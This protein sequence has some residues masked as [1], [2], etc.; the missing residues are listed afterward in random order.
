ME[1]EPAAADVSEEGEVQEQRTNI[2]VDR[3]LQGDFWPPQAVDHYSPRHQQAESLSNVLPAARYPA[4]HPAH[5][6]MLAATETLSPAQLRPDYGRLSPVLYDHPLKR[7]ASANAIASGTKKI[8][9]E[10]ANESSPPSSTSAPSFLQSA[11]QSYE[12][13]MSRPVCTQCLSAG[14]PDCDSRAKCNNCGNT[15]CYYVPCARG[16]ACTDTTCKRIHPDQWKRRV[17]PGCTRWNVVGETDN[18]PRRPSLGHGGQPAMV[19]H[20]VRPPYHCLRNFLEC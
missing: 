5:S 13:H 17:S 10:P 2:I 14:L 15:K 6:L 20:K 18:E 16:L 4:Q 9:I 1:I 19:P 8:K 7:A 11:S 3:Q 12:Q